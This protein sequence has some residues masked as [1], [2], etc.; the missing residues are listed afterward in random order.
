MNVSGE[1]LERVRGTL[2]AQGSEPTPAR[3]AAALRADGEVFGDSTVLAVV[4]ELRRESLG[5]GPL[6]GL[7][8]EP[9]IT[10]IL[11]NCPN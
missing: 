11:V 2:A 5:A 6:D 9:G 3:V 4:E 8:A 1:L 10:D 7:L